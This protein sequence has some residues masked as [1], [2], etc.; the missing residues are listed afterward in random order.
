MPSWFILRHVALI[1]KVTSWCKLAAG[2]PA[3]IYVFQ[4]SGRN[5]GRGRKEEGRKERKEG[6][7]KGKRETHSF[8][9]RNLL[10]SSTRHFS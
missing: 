10:R 1:F 7:R 3:I 6:R 9:L 8:L 5:A 4:I 2:V